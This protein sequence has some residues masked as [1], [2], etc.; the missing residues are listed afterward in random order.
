MGT[1]KGEQSWSPNAKRWWKSTHADYTL[2]A[3]EL[4]LAR[5]VCRQITRL[6]TLNSKLENAPLTQTNRFGE[7]V[8]NPLLVEARQ[9]SGSL[10]KLIGS[11]R[12]PEI[13]VDEQGKTVMGKTPQ[14]RPGARGTYGPYAPASLSVAN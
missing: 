8:P 12:L 7:E 10:A 6:D 14:K 13:D 4:I 5:E 3:S 1:I 9:I 11:L 2:T